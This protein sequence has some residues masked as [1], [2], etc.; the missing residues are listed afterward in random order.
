MML[1]QKISIHTTKKGLEFLRWW[2]GENVK[3]KAFRIS[4][5]VGGSEFES[6]SEGLRKNLFHGGGMDIFWN[7]KF[8]LF[9]I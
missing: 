3:C 1:L 9:T 2:G 6:E 7:Y 5:G 4:R 8:K